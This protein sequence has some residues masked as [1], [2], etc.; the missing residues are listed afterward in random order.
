M[1][2]SLKRRDLK[3]DYKL[4]VKNESQEEDDD[5][6]WNLEEHMRFLD[7]LRKNNSVVLGTDFQKVADEVRTKTY[8]QTLKHA[9]YLHKQITKNSAHPDADVYTYLDQPLHQVQPWTDSEKQR[10]FEAARKVGN[11]PGLIMEFVPTKT[12]K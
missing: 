6:L 8:K 5:V 4:V 2:P 1:E 9:T 10:F 12:R 3:R 7:G 11:N